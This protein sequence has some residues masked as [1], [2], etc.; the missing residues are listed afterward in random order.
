MN[1]ADT[2]R[3]AVPAPLPDEGRKV[4]IPLRL[5]AKIYEVLS[6][7]QFISD[8]DDQDNDDEVIELID[9][10]DQSVGRQV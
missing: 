4:I 10:M 5:W 7:R 9:E 6:A 3:E 1:E 8:G 2:S